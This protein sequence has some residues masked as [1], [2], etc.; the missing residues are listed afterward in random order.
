MNNNRIFTAPFWGYNDSN[1]KSNL[2]YQ[3]NDQQRV[4]IVNVLFELKSLIDNPLTKQIKLFDPIAKK[5]NKWKCPAWNNPVKTVD[6]TDFDPDTNVLDDLITYLSPISYN[7]FGDDIKNKQVIKLNNA[8]KK[9][10][11]CA[12]Y[13]LGPLK[14][15]WINQADILDPDMIGQCFTQM[16]HLRQLI[17]LSRSFEFVK[18]QDATQKDTMVRM[19]QKRID[20]YMADHMTALD[21]YLQKTG[22]VREQ[23]IAE[24]EKKESLKKRLNKAPAAPSKSII[25]NLFTEEAM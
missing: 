14:K 15:E 9:I 25:N 22:K 16:T 6:G 8:L 7:G 2:V 17:D 3:I 19:E 12:K 13:Y 5:G 4:D 18:S 1:T 24:F 11:I 23:W 20:A 21:Y 10:Q